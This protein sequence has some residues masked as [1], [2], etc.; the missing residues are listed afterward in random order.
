MIPTRVNTRPLLD[1]SISLQFERYTPTFE[2]AGHLVNQKDEEMSSPER[3]VLAYL[4]TEEPPIL[5][6]KRLHPDAVLP[7]RRIEGAAGY[8]LTIIQSCKVSPGDRVLLSTG[9]AIAIPEGHY[10]RIAARSGVALKKG[11][12]I[13]VGVIDQ[14]FRGEVKI[15]L[16]NLNYETIL[17][18]K[19]DI[20]AQL[21]IEKISLPQVLEVEELTI[22][23]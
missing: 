2:H 16:F 1:G 6:V 22:T 9:I 11:I 3:E 19:H 15:L 18:V 20:I 13:G 7:Q 8:D 17:L 14:D 4:S 5:Q 10:G 21:I 12:H 23:V